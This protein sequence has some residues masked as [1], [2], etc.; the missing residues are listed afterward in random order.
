MDQLQE[1]EEDGAGRDERPAAANGPAP[2]RRRFLGWMG[3]LGTVVI[4]GIAGAGILEETATA[5]PKY[6]WACCYLAFTPG[7]CPGSGSTFTCPSGWYKRQWTC[8]Y[9]GL[10]R[11]CGE[12]VKLYPAPKPTTCWDAPA[13][14]CSE[15]WTIG[16]TC[17]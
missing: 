7:G 4:G 11:G 6:K 1:R 13:F 12:C 15:G 16:R 3:R 9:G 8:C 17:G 5:R 2:S 10:Q 14:K